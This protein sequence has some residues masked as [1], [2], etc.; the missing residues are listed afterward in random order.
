MLET[1]NTLLRR[2]VLNGFYRGQVLKH[3][4]AGKCKIWIPGVYDEQYV[5]QPDRLPDAEQAA[6][7]FGGSS[8]GSGIFTYPRINAVVWCFFQNGD[9]NLP[10]YFAASNGGPEGVQQYAQIGPVDGY[11]EYGKEHDHIIDN[12]D[13][14]SDAEIHRIN[15]SKGQISFFEDGSIQ[16]TVVKTNPVRAPYNV[17]LPYSESHHILNDLSNVIFPGQVTDAMFVSDS[18]Y[19]YHTNDVVSGLNNAAFGISC[20]INMSPGAVF[21][22]ITSKINACCIKGYKTQCRYVYAK[23]GSASKKKDVV[24]P[25]YIEL[26]DCDTPTAVDYH[27]QMF[28]TI[29]DIDDI[30][31]DKPVYQIT[32]KKKVNEARI[33]GITYR[34]G[35]KIR[36]SKREVCRDISK[37]LV[38]KVEDKNPQCMVLIAAEDCKIDKWDYILSSGYDLFLCSPSEFDNPVLY[39]D[40]KFDDTYPQQCPSAKWP[41]LV[42]PKVAAY[43]ASIILMEDRRKYASTK[44]NKNG[45]I[46]MSLSDSYD[47]SYVSS[48]MSATGDF[49]YNAFKQDYEDWNKTHNYYK[50][51][52]VQ[53]KISGYN[54]MNMGFANDDDKHN[55]YLSVWNYQVRKCSPKSAACWWHYN[56][57]F[58]WDQH[59]GLCMMNNNLSITEKPEYWKGHI[60]EAHF[61]P[62]WKHDKPVNIDLKEHISCGYYMNVNEG[63]AAWNFCHLSNYAE[64]S[65]S[66]MSAD[67][68]G[69][70]S[71]EATK[72][73][74]LLLDDVR[75]SDHPKHCGGTDETWPP[76]PKDINGRCD[77]IP[78]P[79]ASLPG[80]EPFIHNEWTHIKFNREGELSVHG[81][82]FIELSCCDPY[83]QY[84]FTHVLLTCDGTLS[85]NNSRGISLMSMAPPIGRAGPEGSIPKACCDWPVKE[86]KSEMGMP[87]DVVRGGYKDWPFAK[88]GIRNDGDADIDAYHQVDIFAAPH[89]YDHRTWQSQTKS[90]AVGAGPGSDPCAPP[91]AHIR[92]TGA[93]PQADKPLI[94]GTPDQCDPAHKSVSGNPG[95][96]TGD[97]CNKVHFFTSNGSIE[98]DNQNAAATTNITI[99][100][101]NADKTGQGA[102][103]TQ[104]ISIRNDVPAIV[105][106]SGEAKH[107]VVPMID[108][109]GIEIRNCQSS[110]KGIVISNDKATDG[111]FIHNKCGTASGIEIDNLENGPIRIHTADGPIDIITD[112]GGDIT[113]QC[114][115]KCVNILAGGSIHAKAGADIIAEATGVITA[116]AGTSATVTAPTITLNGN[117]VITGTL[118]V[119]KAQTNQAAITASGDVVGAGKS[120]ST[121]THTC[122]DGGTTPPN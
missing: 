74:D 1:T 115:P 28:N 54:A 59:N 15:V 52:A 38:Y 51:E 48:M 26:K 24:K 35:D 63:I 44:L 93:C 10:V 72:E 89:Q 47:E 87:H 13:K 94:E 84:D 83:K 71:V 34:V 88:I 103:P 61:W 55:G 56:N 17:N 36:I 21:N 46:G 92:L 113:I 7:L 97:C 110:T 57:F 82:K 53:A 22:E 99:H 37:A 30:V 33:D 8:N 62:R 122:P 114:V 85:V 39:F 12:T 118:S 105:A 11:E 31:D 79:H 106:A 16:T 95:T 119:A 77:P 29:Y 73:F 69:N 116:T 49:Q 108:P 64:M 27:W 66:R 90:V 2:N 107:G 25:I 50:G 78:N 32:F 96:I 76:A 117:V 68:F 104:G 101:T 6:P 41:S 5:S 14:I 42:D 4:A 23:Q 111:I 100:N 121:H 18:P 86:L 80:T 67:Y 20:N 43:K 70:I 91:R 120:L 45:T 81:T 65:F 9:Q 102:S 60:D 3:C 58:E 75:H 109:G 40:K 19:N 98:I 112:S